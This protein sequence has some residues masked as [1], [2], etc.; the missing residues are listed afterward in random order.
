VVGW[1]SRL[2]EPSRSRGRITSCRCRASLRSAASSRRAS[3][4]S[5]LVALFV[6]DQKLA[7]SARFFMDLSPSTILEPSRS[8]RKVT[9]RMQLCQSPPLFSRAYS[10]SPASS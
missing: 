7:N 6:F 1:T 10:T 2:I 8:T 5:Q 3:S 4:L 9:S